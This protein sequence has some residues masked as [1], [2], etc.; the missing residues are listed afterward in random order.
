[1]WRYGAGVATHGLLLLGSLGVPY[2]IF[3]MFV[4]RKMVP[5]CYPGTEN[6]YYLTQKNFLLCS[7]YL[8]ESLN[9]TWMLRQRTAES[10]LIGQV[11]KLL[12]HVCFLDRL[13]V[14]C[15]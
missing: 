3:F 9:K 4:Y 8:S 11:P 1:M 6:D 10:T 7:N 14:F 5:L 13:I 2:F 12:G 15:P